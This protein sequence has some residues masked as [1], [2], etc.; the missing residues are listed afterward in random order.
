MVLLDRP[1]EAVEAL[2]SIVYPTDEGRRPKINRANGFFQNR[3]AEDAE[4]CYDN[5]SFYIN[6]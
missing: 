3:D 1:T 4:T 6:F 2:N 5:V